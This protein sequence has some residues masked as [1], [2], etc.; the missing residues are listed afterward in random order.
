MENE[1]QM[2]FPESSQQEMV[3]WWCSVCVGAGGGG[4]RCV[5]RRVLMS[6]ETLQ[7][8]IHK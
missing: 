4:S 3:Q 8:E 6:T 5:A 7:N 1:K 2:K